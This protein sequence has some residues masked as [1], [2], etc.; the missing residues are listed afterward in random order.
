MRTHAVVSDYIFSLSFKFCQLSTSLASCGGGH[1]RCSL[2]VRVYARETFVARAILETRVN[3]RT[4]I[5]SWLSVASGRY[6]AF[7]AKQK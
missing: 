2:R 5:L 4:S 6:P 1:S 7:C 3:G